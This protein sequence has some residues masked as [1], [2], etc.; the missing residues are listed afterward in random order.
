MKLRDY[1]DKYGIRSGWLAKKIPCSGTY[2]CAIASGKKVPS[3]LIQNRIIE[4]TNGE[5]TSDDFA[6][7]SGSVET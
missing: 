4:L 5:V 6:I 3:V 2:I 7:E 1:L